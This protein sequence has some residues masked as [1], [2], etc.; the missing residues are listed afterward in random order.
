MTRIGIAGGT[1]FT[2]VVPVETCL[3][4]CGFGAKRLHRPSCMDLH[5]EFEIVLALERFYH[6]H[7]VEVLK[8]QIKIHEIEAER[9]SQKGM[10]RDCVGQKA[11]AWQQWDIEQGINELNNQDALCKHAFSSE[12]RDNCRSLHQANQGAVGE[13][14]AGTRKACQS[15]GYLSDT[16][17]SLLWFFVLPLFCA[18]SFWL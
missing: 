10:P 17:L 8:L 18:A 5:G 4:R 14:P 15:P 16:Y 1:F 13:C 3:L 6:V 9:I 2:Q 7:Q 11:C 12:V